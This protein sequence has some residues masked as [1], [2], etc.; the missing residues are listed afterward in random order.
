MSRPVQFNRPVEFDPSLI[1]QQQQLAAQQQQQTVAARAPYVTKEQAMKSAFGF[2]G[3]EEQ[4]QND[5]DAAVDFN[6]TRSTIRSVNA[7]DDELG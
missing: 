5:D 3:E 1:R 6:I 2:D 7:A 4:K